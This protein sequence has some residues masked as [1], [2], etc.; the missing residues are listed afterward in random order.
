MDRKEIYEVNACSKTKER[1][2]T[3][4]A[5]RRKQQLVEL[6]GQFVLVPLSSSFSVKALGGGR[7]FQDVSYLQFMGTLC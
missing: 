6:N 3:D 4:F 5:R 1:T 2:G 7:R